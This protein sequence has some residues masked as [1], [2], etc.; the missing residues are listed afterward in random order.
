[1]AITARGGQT[2]HGGNK[3]HIIVRD[4]STI[5]KAIYDPARAQFAFVPDNVNG[6]L[7]AAELSTIVGILNVLPR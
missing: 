1:M 7:S 5:G 3:V 6:V 2:Q 4:F